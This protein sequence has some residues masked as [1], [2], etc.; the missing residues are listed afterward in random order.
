MNQG[1]LAGKVLGIIGIV[2]CIIAGIARLTGHYTIGS[3]P[4]ITLFEGGT[5]VMV[6]GC[7]SLLWDLVARR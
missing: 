1:A 3:F 7:F 6:A 4:A 2:M 5:A